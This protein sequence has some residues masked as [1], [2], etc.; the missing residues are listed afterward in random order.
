MRNNIT[1]NSL[2]IMA[3]LAL[4]LAVA[5]SKGNKIELAIEAMS[6]SDGMSLSQAKIILD[7]KEEGETDS[8]GKFNGQIIRKPGTEVELVIKKDAKGYRYE[9]WKKAFIIR[10]P[11]DSAAVDKYEF[12]AELSGGKYITITAKEKDSPISSAQIMIDKKKAGVTNDKGIYEHTYTGA[13]SKEAVISASKA[14]YVTGESRV[15]IEPGAEVVVNLTKYINLNITAQTE[16]YGVVSGIAGIDVYINGKPQGKTNKKGEFVYDYKG[17]PNKKVTVELK[18]ADYIPYS[19]KKDVVL[20]D[21][22][23]LTRYFYPVS[24]KP[25][26]VGIYKFASNLYADNEVKEIISRVHT[27][28]SDSLFDNKAFKEVPTNVLID[29]VKKNK[30]SLDKM[31]GKGWANTN[32]K[33]LIDMIIVGSIGK[34]DKGYTVET[35]VYTSKGKILLSVIKQVKGLRDI[36]SAARDLASEIAERFPF[37][38]TVVAVEDDG[39]KINLG[40]AGGYR[41]SRG[42]EFDVQAAKFD[43]EGKITGVNNIGVVELKKID[44]ASSLAAPV[45]VKGKA[46]IGDKVV[47]KLYEYTEAG[48]KVFFTV[49]VKGGRTGAVKDLSGVNIYLE[50]LWMGATEKDGRFDIPV[51]LGRRYSLILYKHGYQQVKDKVSLDKNKEVKEFQMTPNTAAFKAESSPSGAEVSV[52]GEPLGKTPFTDGKPVELGFHTIKVSVGQDYRDWEDVVEFDK[53][54]ID[55]TGESKIVL[56]KDY[57][58]LGDE[59]YKKGA[60]D[61]AIALYSSTEKG[62]P[63]YSVARHRLAQ[64]YLDDKGDYENAMREFENVLSLPEN[65]QLIYKRFAVTFTNLGHAYYLKANDLIRT[66]RNEAARYFQKAIDNLQTARQNTRF[67]PNDNYD[68]G[69]HDTIYYLA[70]S[71]HKLYLLSKRDTFL[72]NANWAWRDYFDFFPK[73]LEGKAEYEKARDGAKVYWSQIKDKL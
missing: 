17:E 48:D 46:A 43:N 41:L 58:R 30:L 6:A 4:F 10:L 21:S 8:S 49:A 65:Q 59:E 56:H 31:T 70:L 16:D 66:D 62:H 7:N 68:E 32:L 24:P 34:D 51:K 2:L 9:P 53:E 13:F 1:K 5:C 47:R 73:T 36:D 42:M 28:L 23:T 55:K 71:Y 3:V 25:I 57:L 26:K 44:A 67:F 64:I 18:A 22:S 29:E 61:K 12:I 14:G 60:V 40:K 15:K 38:G 27:S 72:R 54:V 69:L 20:K 11:K 63:D 33:K 52:D 50:S 45:N 37:E 19:W 35:K 39:L